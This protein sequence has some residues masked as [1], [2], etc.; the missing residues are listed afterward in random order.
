MLIIN[1]RNIFRFIKGLNCFRRN[2]M[3]IKRLYNRERRLIIT[4]IVAAVFIIFTGVLLITRVGRNSFKD[5]LI[6]KDYEKLYTFIENPDFPLS[7]FNTYMDYNYGG[8]I[9]IVKTEKKQNHIKYTIETD[10]GEK[11]IVLE[12]KNGR[13]FWIFND[14]IYGWNIK[15]PKNA[16]ISIENIQFENKEGEITISRLP[17]AVYQ[18][19]ISAENCKDYNEKVMAGQKLSIKMDIAQ[20]AMNVSQEVIKEYISFKKNAIDFGVIDDI[21]CVEKESGIYKEVIDQVEWLKNTDYKISKELVSLIVEKG[22]V[23]LDGTICLSVIEVWDTTII[24]E[25]GESVT[26]DK[27]KNSYFIDPGD[28]FKIIK[29]KNEQ[30]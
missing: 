24:N 20:S 8:K 3:E 12:E 30:V 18:M 19:S 23:E 14:Y 28:N 9:N 1:N 2:T 6:N 15:I 5:Y 17:F 16:R 27:Y 25:N 11:Y 13:S 7:I 26:T 22:T 21:D 10:T 29:I 4:L